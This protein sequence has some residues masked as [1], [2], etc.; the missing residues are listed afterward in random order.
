MTMYPCLAHPMSSDTILQLECE[1]RR[2]AQH[3]EE[4]R[5]LKANYA[6]VVRSPFPVKPL[7]PVK[8]GP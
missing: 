7:Q 4:L 8:L 3:V 1:R 6:Q 5:A 2:S